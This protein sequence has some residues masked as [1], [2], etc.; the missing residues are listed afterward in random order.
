MSARDLRAAV[1]RLLTV[2]AAWQSAMDD[3]LVSEVIAVIDG[4]PLRFS[5]LL[6][7]LTGLERTQPTREDKRGR[8]LDNEGIGA[9]AEGDQLITWG[10]DI[11]QIEVRT[12]PK[13]GRVFL[14][15]GMLGLDRYRSEETCPQVRLTLTDEHARQLAACITAA[16]DAKAGAK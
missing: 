16:L 12:S 7:V 3:E 13:P 5:D 9:G 2:L 1:K 11:D 8:Y 6:A 14:T 15:L 10:G 4:K